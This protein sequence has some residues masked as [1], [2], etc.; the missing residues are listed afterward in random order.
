MPDRMATVRPD[1]AWEKGVVRHEGAYARIAGAWAPTPNLVPL[2]AGVSSLA[3]YSTDDVV[4]SV[5]VTE[6]ER[7]VGVEPRCTYRGVPFTLS[8]VYNPAGD[9]VWGNVPQGS[10]EFSAS[11][12]LDSGTPHLKRVTSWR[13]FTFDH[14]MWYAHGV[15]P[16]SKIENYEERITE[17]DMPPIRNGVTL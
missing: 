10:A 5:P 9:L 4:V 17:I 14:V 16:L 7:I 8:R 3:I 6:V 1:G 12:I 2:N 15:A 13:A 11:L